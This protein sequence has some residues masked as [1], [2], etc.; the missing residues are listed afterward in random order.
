MG[1]SELFPE[2]QQLNLLRRRKR[3][4]LSFYKCSSY[5][6]KVLFLNFKK[7]TREPCLVKSSGPHYS[8][9]IPENSRKSAREQTLLNLWEYTCHTAPQGTLNPCGQHVQHGQYACSSP[10]E[11]GKSSNTH[12]AHWMITTIYSLVY[13]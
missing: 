3:K 6:I 10:A 5:N 11:E 13:N 2:V 12:H 9:D 8:I 1:H 7:V 4:Y